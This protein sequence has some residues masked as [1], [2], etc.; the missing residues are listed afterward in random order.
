MNDDYYNNY[1]H[2]FNGNGVFTTGSPICG[3]CVG[4]EYVISCG[5]VDHFSKNSADLILQRKLINNQQTLLLTVY[6]D[7]RTHKEGTPPLLNPPIPGG[8]YVLIKQ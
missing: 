4:N 7:T 6:W 2:A 5:L 1:E 3:G 8:D